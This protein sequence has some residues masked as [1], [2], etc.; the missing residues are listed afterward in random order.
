[1]TTTGRVTGRRAGVVTITAA[2]DG[3][4]DTSQVTVTP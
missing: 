4:T 2:L 1:V 3:A